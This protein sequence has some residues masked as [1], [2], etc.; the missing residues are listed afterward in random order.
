M[1]VDRRLPALSSFLGH[2]PTQEIKTRRRGKSAHVSADFGANDSCTEFAD[3][4]N[5]SQQFDGDAK[6]GNTSFHLAID[7]AKSGINGIDLLKVQPQQEAVVRHDPATQRLTQLLGRCFDARMASAASLVGPVSPAI[8]ASS[9][10]RPLKPMMSVMAE[11][12]LILA[13]SR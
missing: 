6:G 3:S 10:R 7:L 9:I 4:R 13:S 8:R 5:R 12:S 2:R 11:S 1:R